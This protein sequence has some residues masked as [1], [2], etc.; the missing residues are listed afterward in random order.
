M[1][2]N[3]LLLALVLGCKDSKPRVETTDEATFAAES[4]DTGRWAGGAE[5]DG[6]IVEPPHQWLLSGTL[7][8][9]EG[10]VV[11]PLSS[12]RA[13]VENEDD[14]FICR[15]GAA[16]RSVEGA[17]AIP[18]PDIDSWWGLELVPDT[19]GDCTDMGISNPLPSSLS[20]GL[21]PMHPE[22]EAVL[23]SEAGDNPPSS[24]LAKSVFVS[25]GNQGDIWVFGLA[26]LDTGGSDGTVNDYTDRFSTPDG[27]WKFSAL[28][29][30]PY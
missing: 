26:L 22:I 19:I 4:L 7:V 3:F 30:F 27:H 21:G 14:V 12:L 17:T 10:L 23:G 1:G 5:D 24:H 9:Q 16:I 13:S 8:I 28:Y 29:A 2:R 18:D 6:Q 20:I 25:L 11:T 15:Q